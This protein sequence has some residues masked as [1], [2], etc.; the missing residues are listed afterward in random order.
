MMYLGQSFV[1]FQLSSFR[2]TDDHLQ[3]PVLP[4]NNCNLNEHTIQLH[5]YIIVMYLGRNEKSN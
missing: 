4:A 3:R 1:S 5:H 2:P